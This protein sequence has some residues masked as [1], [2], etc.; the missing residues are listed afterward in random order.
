ML[1]YR[2]FGSMEDGTLSLSELL[3]LR[4]L[5]TLDS[6]VKGDKKDVQNFGGQKLRKTVR[7]PRVGWDGNV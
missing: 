2:I 6:V 7:R 5:R 1:N 4:T 3:E